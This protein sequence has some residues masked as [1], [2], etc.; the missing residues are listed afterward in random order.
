MLFFTQGVNKPHFLTQIASGLKKNN[1]LVAIGTGG[2]YN[3]VPELIQ[4]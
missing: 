1:S 3:G 4:T 2:T